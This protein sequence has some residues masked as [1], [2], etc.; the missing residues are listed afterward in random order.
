MGYQL[1]V[2]KEYVSKYNA[3]VHVIHWDKKNLTPYKP[4][5]ID[6]VFYYT[7]S[8]FNSKEL[9]HFSK[10]I[11][12]DITFVSGWMDLQYLRATFYI[13][14]NKGIVVCGFDDIWF[15]TLKQRLASLFFPFL[16]KYFFSH[17]WVTGPLQFEY[18]KRLGFKN[19]ETIHNCYSA[20]TDIFNN[21]FEKSKKNKEAKYPHRFLFVGR[22]ESVKG[23]DILVKAW[24]NIKKKNL[25]KDWELTLIGN[26]SFYN[27]LSKSDLYE[28]ISFMQPKDLV[29]EIKNFGCFLLP[30]TFEPWALVI[31]E[32]ATAGLPIICSDICGAAP[33]FVID[34]YNGYTF[35]SG[36]SS[37]L[38]V[39][40][41]KIINS[42]DE[43]L[44]QMSKRSNS[45]GKRITPE[46][47]A[48][49]FMSLVNNN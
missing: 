36:N 40:M 39:K 41:I 16:K 2:L 10:K 37:N 17:A 34:N 48:A 28:A 9:V 33:M 5:L 49:S 46:L 47:T 20:D 44:I 24:S 13:R 1:P 35:K 31:H 45:L 26:G 23:I 4:E 6:G 7:R 15:K 43:E 14:R 42:S 38:E 21:E 30:S 18:A 3:E 8:S 25:S 32:F 12:P 22:F 19:F 27:Q 11:D 29:C